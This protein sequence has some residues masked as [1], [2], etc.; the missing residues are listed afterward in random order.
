MRNTLHLRPDERKQP[1]RTTDQQSLP[2]HYEGNTPRN[3]WL[4]RIKRGDAT[5]III[6]IIPH[7]PRDLDF[8]NQRHSMLWPKDMYFIGRKYRLRPHHPSTSHAGKPA[9]GKRR[10]RI[11]PPEFAAPLRIFQS[12][13][14]LSG[15][16][17]TVFSPSFSRGETR[18]SRRRA[19]ATEAYDRPVWRST[20]GRGFHNRT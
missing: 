11:D 10:R 18:R 8:P 5:M 7:E 6:T 19:T 17:N 15:D 3:Q 12:T 16:M 14:S 13:E 20:A 2:V 1:R 4:G 9:P